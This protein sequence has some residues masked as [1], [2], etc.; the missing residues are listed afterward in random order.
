MDINSENDEKIT[1]FVIGPIGDRDAENGSP[2]RKIYESSMEVLEHIIVP[3]CASLGVNTDRSDRIARTGE[4]TEQ[5]FR[6]LRDAPIVIADL[7]D[8]NPNVMYELGL[9]HSI[10][11]LTIQI[12]ER[13]RLPFD[14]STIRTILFKRTE[15]GFIEARRALVKALVHGID[16]GGDPVTATRIWNEKKYVGGQEIAPDDG[17][18]DSLGF[19]EKLADMEDGMNLIIQAVNAAVSIMHEVNDIATEGTK[20][21]EALPSNGSYSSSKLAVVNRVAS[22]LTGPSRRLK[23]ITDDY[24][25]QVKRSLP[26]IEY[27][28]SEL[29]NSSEKPKEAGGFFMAI[30]LLIEN[31]DNSIGPSISFAQS[32]LESG[33]AARSMREVSTAISQSVHNMVKTSR[34]LV[35]LR[36]YLDDAEGREI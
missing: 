6:Y 29:S 36:T 21:M 4:I 19:L 13:N 11:K 12:G 27:L 23:Q 9:R 15:V 18:D 33:R 22:K 7:T 31:V 26:G 28:L 5:I 3:A 17:G 2:S 16:S 1:A 34:T 10:G 20:D 32:I 14:V 8:A 24:A 30:H 25:M 35:D